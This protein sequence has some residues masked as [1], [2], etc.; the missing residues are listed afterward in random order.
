MMS[1]RSIFVAIFSILVL[2]VWM[3]LELGLQA[4]LLQSLQAP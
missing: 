4:D 1:F 3:G 2:R